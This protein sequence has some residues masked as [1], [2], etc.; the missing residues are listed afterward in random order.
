MSEYKIQIDS[1]MKELIIKNGNEPEF[2]QAV[3]E[4]AETVIPF[5]ENNTKYKSAKILKRIVEPERVIQFRV[6]WIDDA[7]AN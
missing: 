3:E 6:P 7:G 1:F 5:I 4:V 2:I